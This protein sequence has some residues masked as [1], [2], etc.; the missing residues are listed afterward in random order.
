MNEHT[1]K[2]VR[3]RTMF[4]FVHVRSCS[5]MFRSC[6]VHVSFKFHENGFLRPWKTVFYGFLRPWKTVFY[7]F[8]RPWKTAMKNGGI[9]LKNVHDTNEHLTNERNMNE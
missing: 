9:F 3:E 2:F 8:L 6:F 4:M 5:F 7:G 1:E